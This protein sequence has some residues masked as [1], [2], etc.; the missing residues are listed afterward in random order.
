MC[1]FLSLRVVGFCFVLF[2][3]QYS[4]FHL[5]RII[6]SPDP[7]VHHVSVTA[8][9]S[10][11]FT[12][13]LPT[14]LSVLPLSVQCAALNSSQS[15]LQIC[16]DMCPLSLVLFLST[17]HFCWFVVETGSQVSV[18]GGPPT[19]CVAEGDLELMVSCFLLPTS[20]FWH[21][22]PH[23]PVS[24]GLC[25]AFRIWGL[26]RQLT[27]QSQKQ[28]HSNTNNVL[29]FTVARLLCLHKYAHLCLLAINGSLYL[30]TS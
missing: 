16:D 21:P 29:D 8:P 10:I 24:Y 12:T 18:P 14:N 28:T 25:S 1:A 30:P 6:F 13:Y 27:V 22:L 9:C 19:P 17:L 20:G 15:K 3:K 11:C 5:F 23:P 26:E 7:H 4:P 2:F